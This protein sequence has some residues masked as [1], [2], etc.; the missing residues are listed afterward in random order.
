MAAVITFTVSFGAS[1]RAYAGLGKNT[2]V[3]V[4]L[5]VPVEAL[6]VSFSALTV[7][8]AAVLAAGRTTR[9]TAGRRR[10]IR[11]GITILGFGVIGWYAAYALAVDKVSTAVDPAAELGCNISLLLQ[12]GANLD[13]WQG[14]VFGFPN[15]LIGLA[16]WPAV[17][18]VGCLVATGIRL[19]PWFWI[20]F[21]LGVAAAL[22]FVCWLIAQS[23]FVLGTL[24]PWCLVTWA[25]TI[26]LF[27][28]V[29]LHNVRERLFGRSAARALGWSFN[30][31]PL[32]TV[33][34]YI[35]V[36]LLAQLRLD[37]LSYL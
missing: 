35:V 22:G 1:A 27:W 6:V 20:A 36:A 11:L 26:P 32:I 5:G 17:V 4:V 37:A 21:N 9:S 24:C 30:W 16:A 34:S 28:T 14:S 8:L 18:V 33:A 15:P 7:V 12:C 13:S 2:D 3:V 19:A 23:I 10:N 25:V 31:V 29:T